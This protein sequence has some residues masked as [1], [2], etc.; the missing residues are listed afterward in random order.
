VAWAVYRWHF[1]QPDQN[2]TSPNL[3]ALLRRAFPFALAAVFAALQVR[4]S[5]ILLEQL[6]TTAEVGY[7][8]AAARF[9]E[10]AKLVPN[11]FFGALFPALAALAADHALR[12]QTF[13]R[14][15]LGLGAV[16]LASG[17]GFSLLALPL[18]LL[19]Y[20]DAFAPAAPVLQVLGW[21]L[22]FSNLRGG[23]TLYLYAL[24][25]ENRVNRINALVVLAQGGLSLLLIPTAGAVGVAI[26]HG[27]V[28]IIAL[29]LLWRDEKT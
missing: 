12:Q 8:S 9:V 5:V 13:R 11:A 23:R 2:T 21:S 14:G 17:V 18:I 10:A 22:L 24:G 3:S 1:Y 29:A 28:E 4:L 15:L 6:A 20:G 27:V 25:Q 26:V 7:F 19:T 16:G